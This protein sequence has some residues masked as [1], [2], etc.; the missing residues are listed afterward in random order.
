MRN[1]LEST[2]GHNCGSEAASPRFFGHNLTAKIAATV[3]AATAGACDGID[4]DG[5]GR[6]RQPAQP[7]AC[8][9]KQIP[10][11]PVILNH[12]L[13]GNRL[14]V[15]F[16]VPEFD[17]TCLLPISVSILAT[18]TGSRYDNEAELESSVKVTTP[19]IKFADFIIP[20][21]IGSIPSFQLVLT[22]ADGGREYSDPVSMM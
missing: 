19:G 12:T 17:K 10:P 6:G 13:E 18:T 7:D 3:L 11:R 14:R 16:T 1:S 5:F 8:E 2:G 22:G 20:A 9:K 4:I 15:H 21:S